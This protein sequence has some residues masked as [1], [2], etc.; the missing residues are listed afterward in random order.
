MLQPRKY[1]DIPQNDNLPVDVTER[2]END[3][4]DPNTPYREEEDV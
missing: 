4:V 1:F 3:M 2:G